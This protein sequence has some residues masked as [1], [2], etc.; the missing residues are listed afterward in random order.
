MCSIQKS[1]PYL[2]PLP[3]P[4]FVLVTFLVHIRWCSSSSGWPIADEKVLLSE[5]Y[6]IR[7]VLKTLSLGS[8]RQSSHKAQELRRKSG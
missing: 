2:D 1:G 4:L 5:L 7:S 8:D 6:E 3:W